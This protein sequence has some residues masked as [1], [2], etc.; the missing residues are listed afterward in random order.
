LWEGGLRRR[1]VA[2]DAENRLDIAE[3]ILKPKTLGDVTNSEALRDL[4]SRLLA[5]V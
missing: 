2:I 3:R 5:G 4:Q 1:E